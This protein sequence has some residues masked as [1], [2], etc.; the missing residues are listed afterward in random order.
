MCTNICFWYIPPRM[1]GL[2]ETSEWWQELGKVFTFV[3][4]I[5]LR[6]YRPRSEASE[7]YV[8]TCICLSNFGGS[9]SSQNASLVT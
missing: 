3:D 2:P 1:R 4:D 5:L 9:A 6:Y 7:G 8:F